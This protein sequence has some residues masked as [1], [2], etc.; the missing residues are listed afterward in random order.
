MMRAA[1]IEIEWHPDLPIFSSEKFLESVSDEYGWLGGTEDQGKLCCILPYTIIRK[2]IF[3]MVRFRTETML[4]DQLD[5]Q[6]EKSFLNSAV[7]YFRSKNVDLVIPATTNS[8]FRTYPDGAEAAPYGSYVIDLTQSEDTLW[9]NIDRITRQ[10]IKSASRS[11][12]L[13]RDAVREELDRA[14]FLI[15]E[16]FKRSKLPF[17]R[18]GSFRT[19]LSGLG[20]YGKVLV[21]D[22]EGTAQ[23]Y[24][25]FA[26]SNYCA[27]AIYA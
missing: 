17:M 24:V 22:Y 2:G 1:P 10:N 5:V 23:S 19:F 16:T 14:F 27:Y 13:I 18:L 26:Y 4:L 21:A 8:I 12:I 3:R 15:R 6:D 25:V 7:E 9:K 20:E 11:G